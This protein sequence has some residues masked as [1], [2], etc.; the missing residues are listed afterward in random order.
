VNQL[1]LFNPEQSDAER[2]AGMDL[3]AGNKRETLAHARAVAQRLAASRPDGITAD[4]V[5]REMIIDGFDIHCLGNAAGS[6][7][8]GGWRWTG[9]FRKSVRVH[10]HSNLL[11]VWV[12]RGTE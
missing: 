8:K 7:F 6:L 4:D 5:M 3:A 12:P 2:I 11:R 9:E 1:A 10:A